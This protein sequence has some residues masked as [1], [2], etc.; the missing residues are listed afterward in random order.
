MDMCFQWRSHPNAHFPLSTVTCGNAANVGQNAANSGHSRL[1]IVTVSEHCCDTM[2][3]WANFACDMH[4]DRF[5]CPDAM[6][7]FESTNRSYGLI[8]HDG[9]SAVIKISFCPWCGSKLDG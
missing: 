9:G 1:E 3:Y 8:V 2:S 5:A 7:D 6:I 4:P